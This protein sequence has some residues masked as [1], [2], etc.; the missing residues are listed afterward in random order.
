MSRP[1]VDPLLDSGL[2]YRL[3]AARDCNTTYR[4]LDDINMMRAYD[5]CKIVTMY[6]AGVMTNPEDKMPAL[7]GVAAQ[8]K[9]LSGWFSVAGAWVDIFPN[10]LL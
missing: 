4:E 5:W 3:L 1:M 2:R 6:T 9:H 8:W 7:S 10:C